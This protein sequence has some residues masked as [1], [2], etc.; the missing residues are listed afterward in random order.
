MRAKMTQ[1]NL[2]QC[3]TNQK[4]KKTQSKTKTDPK[5]YKTKQHKINQKD[6]KR[7]KMISRLT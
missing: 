4:G 5:I 3:K 1:N 6:Q 2:K 7:F